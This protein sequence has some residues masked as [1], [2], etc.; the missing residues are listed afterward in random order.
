MFRKILIFTLVTINLIAQENNIFD[1]SYLGHTEEV[2]KLLESGTNIN[3]KDRDG[4]TLLLLVSQNPY[5]T[6]DIANLLIQHGIDINA[7]NNQGK[8][9][10]DYANERGN[11]ALA[12]LLKSKGAIEKIQIPNPQKDQ[13]QKNISLI[14][15]SKNGQLEEVKSLIANGAQVNTVDFKNQT[16]LIYATIAGSPEVVKFLID[17]GA[18]VNI[19]GDNTALGYADIYERKEIEKLLRAAGAK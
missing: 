7:K 6:P 13:Y 15:A 5:N 10:L 3:I 11:K 12:N 2:K 17:H 19:R 14:E 4:N 18:D 8:T 1:A 16:P 9:A